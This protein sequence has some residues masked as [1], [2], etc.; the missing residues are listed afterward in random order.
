MGTREDLLAA[1]KR[2]LAERGYARTTVREIVAASGSNLAAINYH[3]GTRD[4]LLNQAMIESS[5]E[6]VQRIAAALPRDD[7]DTPA[8][9]L[10]AFWRELIASFTADRPLWSANIE[11]MA[12]ALHSPQVRAELAVAQER[13]RES[14]WQLFGPTRGA[15]ADRAVGAVLHA[16]IGGLMAQWLVDPEHAPS[17]DDLIAGL[18][19]LAGEIGAD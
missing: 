3:F 12:Q 2:C 5:A 8:A 10:E 6:A 9:R 11:G 7:S 16:L 17:P 18:R 15:E 1:A 4:K 14:I 13:A 19:T